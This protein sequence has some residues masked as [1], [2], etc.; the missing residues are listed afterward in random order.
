[1]AESR[2]ISRQHPGTAD[3]PRQEPAKASASETDELVMTLNKTTHEVLKVARLD[4]SGRRHELSEEQSAELAGQAVAGVLVHSL[5]DAFQAGLAE[6]LATR[7]D[8]EEVDD[9]ILVRLL[10]S[11]DAPPAVPGPGLSGTLLRPLLLRR[12]LR[13]HVPSAPEVHP[14]AAQNGSASHT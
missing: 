8:E 11:G 6:G 5:D 14:Q 7:S 4:A 10:V 9:D 2:K 12:L 3:P 1:M 13:Q